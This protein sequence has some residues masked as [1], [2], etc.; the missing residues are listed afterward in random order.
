MV[1]QKPKGLPSNAFTEL[2]AGEKYEPIV[3]PEKNPPEITFRAIFWGIIMCVVFSG[4]TAFLGLKIGQVFE[5][6][7]PIAILAVGLSQLYG[8]FGRKNTVLENVIIQ[9]IGAASGVV[10]AGA[11]FTIPAI[12]ILG[13]DD[14]LGKNFEDQLIKIAF[15]SMLGGGLGILFLIPFRKYFVSEMHGKFPFPEATATTGVLVAGE[16]GG[17]QAKVLSISMLIGGVYDFLVEPIGLFREVFETRILKIG[18]ALA[19]KA[20]LVF[21]VDIL[22]AVTGLGYIVGLKFGAIIASGSFVSWFLLVPMVYFFGSELTVPIAPASDMLIKDMSAEQIFGNYVRLIGIGGIAC[23]GV[24]GIIKSS[25]MIFR[26]F[27]MGFKELFKRKGDGEK[28][29][30]TNK[31]IPMAFILIGILILLGLIFVFF[32]YM[33]LDPASLEGLTAESNTVSLIALVVVLVIS[34]LFTTVAARAIAI[35]GTNPVSGMTLMT[36]ILSSVILVIAGL[37][38]PVGMVA[39]L[40]VGGVVCTALSMAGGLITD[41]KIGYWIGSTP[42]RQERFKFL[43]TIVAAFSVGLIIIILNDAYGF[44]KSVEHP[45]P[46]VAPQANAM[47]AVIETL[48]SD[49]PVP[50]LLYGVGVLV[51]LTMELIGIPPLAFALGMYIPLELNTP[52]LLGGLVSHLVRRSTKDETL[53]QKRFEKGT[54]IASGFIAG[55]AIMGVVGAILT[56]FEV[57]IDI[58]FAHTNGGH[59]L[60]LMMFL[61]ICGYLYWASTRVKA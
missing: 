45:K 20:K 60:S 59:F 27:K 21:K 47:K 44:V 43:G 40:L 46:L 26:A 1:E 35:I 14:L 22:A 52:I 19:D 3:G 6:A 51:A 38:G 57:N 23:A 10:V 15:V 24:I 53:S 31:D 55:G 12:F 41:L 32:R 37:K 4:A 54:L 48:M 50:W 49:A 58:G 5:A 8:G 29:D 25:G 36:L 30:R 33:V 56:F 9:S 16:T 39:A 11:I 61:G 2:K 28:V 13:S 17:D 18:E 7:I 34:F 42:A